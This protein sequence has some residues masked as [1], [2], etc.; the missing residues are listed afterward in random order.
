MGSD[1]NGWI[2]SNELIVNRSEC[3]LSFLIVSSFLIPTD[4]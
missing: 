1:W 3:V 2:C 4:V